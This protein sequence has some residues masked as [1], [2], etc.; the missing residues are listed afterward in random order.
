MEHQESVVARNAQIVGI[1]ALAAGVLGGLAGKLLSSQR[2]PTRQERVQMALADLTGRD[3]ESIKSAIAAETSKAQAKLSELAD[4]AQREGK[5]GRMQAKQKRRDA[6]K[7]AEQGRKDARKQ[8]KALSASGVSFGEHMKQALREGA[9][10]AAAA[11]QETLNE[12]T[13]SL[14]HLSTDLDN[15]SSAA[16]KQLKERG[17]Q[18]RKHAEAAR[19]ELRH[20]AQEGRKDLKVLRKQTRDRSE[21][22]LDQIE[23]I[24][25]EMVDKAKPKVE[26]AA[27][28]A[29]AT[30]AEARKWAEDE[31]KQLE[32]R[33]EQAK[34]KIEK[35]A[36][37]YADR[38]QELG[39][40]LRETAGERA[41][42]AEKAFRDGSVQARQ[43]AHD[44]GESAKKG[45][46]DFTSLMMWLG[47]GAGLVY[48]VF[49]DDDQKKKARELAKSTYHEGM[50]IYN[51]LCGENADFE[52][53]V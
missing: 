44:A 3:V 52:S 9:G 49:L 5:K 22:T 37:Q 20:R 21:E 39:A 13:S 47:I 46:K 1:A 4:A 15:A 24:A 25:R 38:A 27:E 31:A 30:A 48:L 26:K 53:A 45:G 50:G 36:E 17:E 43:L 19:E 23:T 35:A 8:A 40:G 7:R 41:H 12:T 16:S 42:E 51:D 14:S 6:R 10:Q 2:E 28:S 18:A 33:Y 34:P 32:K 29:S 11:L